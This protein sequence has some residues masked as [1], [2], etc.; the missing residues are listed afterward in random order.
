MQRLLLI[1]NGA[2]LVAGLA[3][4]VVAAAVAV[5]PA[6]FSPGAQLPLR[7]AGVDAGRGAGERRVVDVG[8]HAVGGARGFA[9]GVE[10]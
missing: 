2:L 4:G 5:L 1:E 6:L 8:G 3:L 10:K 7:I 9:G